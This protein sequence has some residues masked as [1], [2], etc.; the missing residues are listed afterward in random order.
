MLRYPPL[1]LPPQWPPPPS[2][3]HGLHVL[4]MQPEKSRFSVLIECIKDDQ[5]EERLLRPWAIRCKDGHS[6]P[7]INTM[8]VETIVMQ[9]PDDS[10]ICGAFHMTK[11]RNV[12]SI[13]ATEL[14]LG[15]AVFRKAGLMSCVGLFP[16]L[17]PGTG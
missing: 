13:L 10:E 3:Y 8:A 2:L 17:T 6:R 5:G 1:H 11:M 4:K 16:R 15:Q 14:L 12:G 9:T 7:N